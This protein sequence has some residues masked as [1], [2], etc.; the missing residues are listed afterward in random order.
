MESFIYQMPVKVYF[1]QNGVR[2]HLASELKKYGPNI[3]L[4]YG[5]G[6][7]KRIGLYDE[8]LEILKACGKNVVE[9]SDIPA[10]PTY[11]KVQE[12]IELYRDNHVDLI[13]AAGWGSVVDC[14]KV[15]TAGVYEEGDLWQAQMDEGRIAEKMGNFAVVLTLSGAGAEMDNLGAITK[16]NDKK[17]FVG[18]YA[19]FVVLDPTYI[20]DLPFTSFMPGAFD[21]LTHCMETYF[22]HGYNVSDRMNEG[23]MKDIIANMYAMINGNDSLEVR[24]NL[25]WDSSLIQTFLFNVGKPGDFQAHSIENT[26]GAYSHGTHGK[27]LAIIQPAYYR[28]VYENEM[29][30]FATFARNVFD[31]KEADNKKAA[32]SGLECLE[33]LIDEAKLPRTFK[34]AGYELTEEVAKAISM[35][36]PISMNG[37]RMLTREEVFSMLMKLR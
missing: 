5:K 23:I 8:L 1:G 22:G 28:A 4:A 13:I 12:G 31:V 29:D 10:N 14:V 3:M 30:K 9:L 7:I 27:Q 24:S 32:E 6:A 21:S 25:M 26:L 15:I 17:T 33:K 36:C 20:K 18:S 19:K 37:P 34:E 2:E 35:K 16:D 11:E